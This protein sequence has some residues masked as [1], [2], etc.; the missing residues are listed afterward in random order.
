M[1]NVPHFIIN[2]L[3]LVFPTIFL[4]AKQFDMCSIVP[5]LILK[6]FILFHLMLVLVAVF[7]LLIMMYRGGGQ[8]TET[9]PQRLGTVENVHCYRMRSSVAGQSF[10]YD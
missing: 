2:F 3:L 7:F 1:D 4:G 10:R 9:K 8:V 6:A 5:K